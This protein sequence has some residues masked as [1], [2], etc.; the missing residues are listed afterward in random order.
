MGALG[1]T[2]R[3]RGSRRVGIA[4]EWLGGATCTVEETCA[5][6]ST[7]AAE[8]IEEGVAGVAARRASAPVLPK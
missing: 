4:L 8:L 7:Q 6:D 1:C 3:T 2:Q 5:L